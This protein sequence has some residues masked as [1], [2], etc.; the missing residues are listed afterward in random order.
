MKTIKNKKDFVKLIILPIFAVILFITIS[1][2]IFLNIFENKKR[3]IVEKYKVLT[4]INLKLNLDKDFQTLNNLLN[5]Y[6]I[7]DD[8]YKAL[9]QNN[10]T[11]FNNIWELDKEVADC[12]SYGII[13][14]NGKVFLSKNFIFNK[15]QIE[16]IL[17]YLK[18]QVNIGDE[19]TFFNF[20][21]KNEK[22]KK[23][24]FVALS[25]LANTK[26]YI[27]S[28]DF[29]Y[30]AKKLNPK[31]I[32]QIT[33]SKV[34]IS[35]KKLKNSLISYPLKDFSNT[36]IGYI[37][38]FFP[39][40]LK[41]SFDLVMHFACFLTF[42]AIV[43]GI[44]VIYFTAYIVFKKKEEDIKKFLK[45]IKTIASDQDKINDD[46]YNEIVKLIFYD[47][48]TQAYNRK[49][50]FYILKKEIEKSRR[51]KYP[52]SLIYI[53]LDDFKKINDTYGHRVGD[54][55]LKYFSNLILKN[56]RKAD[57]FARL[58]GEEFAILLPEMKVEEAKKVAER[59]LALI[60]ATPYEGIKLSA[61][62]GITQLRDDDTLE[63]FLD[64]ADKA[65]Y[66]AK[67]S[68]KGRIKVLL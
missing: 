5:S 38:I 6:A 34:Q 61:S 18:S 55:I 54:E 42:V 36:T 62:I 64:R 57:I 40:W 15:T 20:F 12:D 22:D 3:D 45:K 11:F 10:Y 21:I 8:F 51:F 68:G 67:N 31:E 25:P 30:F 52:L 37:N 19:Y 2:F 58:G 56:I 41:S 16:S 14:E 33:L 43:F 29:L 17:S 50:F 49:Y 7:W 26:G 59:L 66:F 53:D 13:K 28:Y 60:K 65:M 46:L 39:F 35:S 9:K 27:L 44:S 47:P 1:F 23:Y 48:L 4:E 32:S 63:T 24:Y